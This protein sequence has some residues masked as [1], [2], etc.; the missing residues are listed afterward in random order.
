MLMRGRA[1]SLDAAALVDRDIYN[2]ATG[3]HPG[4]GLFRHNNR[5]PRGRNQHRAD[6][7]IC[8]SHLGIDVR[9]IRH[10]GDHAAAI[11]HVER[12]EFLRIEIKNGDASAHSC[13]HLHRM[14]AGIS[15][16]DDHDVT[17]HCARDATRQH[18]RTAVLR[19][20]KIRADLNRETTCNL[21]HRLQEREAAVGTLDGFVRNPEDAFLQKNLG[22]FRSR[23]QMQISKQRLPLLQQFELRRQR[24]LHLE[25]KVRGPPDFRRVGDHRRT[26]VTIFRIGESR[27]HTRRFLDQHPRSERNAPTAQTGTHRNARLA[28]LNLLRDADCH[29]AEKI[30]K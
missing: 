4:N 16:A 24:L 17:R 22:Q 18:T 19:L 12:F 26:R 2:H 25:D 10:E 14:R 9:G 30:I 6:Q 28:N 1:N 15:C 11:F 8:V 20:Q 7:K 5:R 21:R 27:G 23:G 13:C 29:G 3:P